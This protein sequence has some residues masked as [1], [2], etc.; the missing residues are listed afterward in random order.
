MWLHRMQLKLRLTPWVVHAA[1]GGCALDHHTSL[2]GSPHDVAVSSMP[3]LAARTETPLGHSV[4]GWFHMLRGRNRAS[5]LHN[6]EKTAVAMKTDG[7]GKSV[8][9]MENTAGGITLAASR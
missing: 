3:G 8:S 7:R 5:R 4:T 1:T 2:C 6:K 9:R